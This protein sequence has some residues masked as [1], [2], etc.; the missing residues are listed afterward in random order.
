L[1]VFD[2]SAKMISKVAVVNVDAWKKYMVEFPIDF[3]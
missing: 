2:D 3:I 1:P